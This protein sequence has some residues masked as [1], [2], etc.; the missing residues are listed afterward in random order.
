M[1]GVNEQKTYS[2]LSKYVNRSKQTR[3]RIFA[4]QGK[5]ENIEFK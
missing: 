3:I 1:L 2:M 5:I 4:N